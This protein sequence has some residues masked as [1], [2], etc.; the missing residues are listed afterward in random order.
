MFL[1]RQDKKKDNKDMKIYIYNFVKK[2]RV[3]MALAR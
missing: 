2:S 1:D 3:N